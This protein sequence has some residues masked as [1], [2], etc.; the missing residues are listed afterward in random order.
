MAESEIP[1][2]WD[3]IFIGLVAGGASIT[4]G[5]YLIVDGGAIAPLPLVVILVGAFFFAAGVKQLR[6]QH[7]RD[8]SMIPF[9][10]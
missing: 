1:P 10:D 2:T 9:S 8:M 5:I 7:R 6:K 4:G 3:R